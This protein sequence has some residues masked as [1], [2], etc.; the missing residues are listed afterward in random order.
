LTHI[1][2]I[3]SVMYNVI[4]ILLRAHV[5]AACTVSLWVAQL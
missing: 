5:F 3:V 2:F 4:P 1:Y